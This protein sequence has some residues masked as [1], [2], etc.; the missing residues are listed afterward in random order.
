MR[1]EGEPWLVGKS[2]QQE[3]EQQPKCLDELVDQLVVTFLMQILMNLNEI[4]TPL[5]LNQ[6]KAFWRDFSSRRRVQQ[7]RAKHKHTHKSDGAAATGADEDED[8]LLRDPET[9]AVISI[10]PREGDAYLEHYVSDQVALPPY[11]Q[12]NVDGS[13]YDYA[14]LSVQYGYIS[15]FAIVFPLAPAIGM[16][17]CA[18][19]LKVD[20]FKLYSL[21]RRPTPMNA[22]HIGSWYFVLQAISLLAVFTNICLIAF[23]FRT[24]DEMDVVFGDSFREQDQRAFIGMFVVVMLMLF[25]KLFIATAIPDVPLKVQDAAKRHAAIVERVTKADEIVPKPNLTVNDIPPGIDPPRTHV[26]KRPAHM[27]GSTA[28]KLRRAYFN[29][30]GML[31]PQLPAFANA[32]GSRRQGSL[33]TA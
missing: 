4:G 23:T 18:I 9:G 25:L 33:K 13:F 20:G 19:E 5:V 29:M 28:G 31:P 17:L 10:E 27:F 24:F 22:E 11:G 8:L 12:K 16:L 14:E 30:T 3:P 21:T 32:H 15:L 7:L 26:N 1:Q 2:I 6:L